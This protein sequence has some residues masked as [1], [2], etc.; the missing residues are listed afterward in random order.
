MTVVSKELIWR[1]RAVEQ[2]FNRHYLSVVASID[3]NP[4]KADCQ[5]TSWGAIFHMSGNPNNNVFNR[6]SA[7]GPGMLNDLDR[8]E[9]AFEER[10][11][12]PNLEVTAG[13]VIAE[14][15]MEGF[16][17]LAARGYQVCEVEG[18][19]FSETSND[20]APSS[21]RVEVRR[22]VE[23]D[24]IQTFLDVY[25]RG[26][27]Y[28]E[29]TWDTWK[30][31][32]PGLWEAEEFS[33]FLAL[34]EGRPA[35]TA[36]LFMRDGIGYFADSCVVT[37]ERRQGCQRAL[38][39]ARLEIS[40]EADCELVFSMAEFASQSANN[41]EAFGLRMATELWHWRKEPS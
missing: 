29:E 5:D 41:M 19:F 10:G 34:V 35:G 13:D 21:D 17:R 1:L 28:P 14:G 33:A 37:E 27:N 36:Q 25:L 20:F 23:S 24:D 8:I 39:D 26:W 16:A 11:I 40:R 38:F 4:R 22:V 32:A 31:A 15:G 30:K 7:C 18:V 9:T 6:A 3:G 12:R 2:A